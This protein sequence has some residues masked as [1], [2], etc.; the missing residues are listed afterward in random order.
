MIP[1]PTKTRPKF[2]VISTPVPVAYLTPI[3]TDTHPASSKGMTK[4]RQR[5]W[6]RLDDAFRKATAKLTPNSI[7]TSSSSTTAMIG[8]IQLPFLR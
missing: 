3:F 1:I 7:A 8:L 5:N 4:V 2:L 6:I